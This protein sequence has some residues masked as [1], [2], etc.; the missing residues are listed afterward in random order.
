M[1]FLF[2][3]ILFF[4]IL[5]LVFVNFFWFY[6]EYKGN[7]WMCRK[8]INNNSKNFGFCYVEYML[9]FFLVYGDYSCGIVVFI[10]Y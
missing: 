9:V 5:R 6:L 10:L 2:M 8:G 4:E 7:K 1:M 3:R